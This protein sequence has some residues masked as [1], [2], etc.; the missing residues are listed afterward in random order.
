MRLWLVPHGA[1]ASEG[2]YLAYPLDDLLRLLALESHRHS[3]IVIGEDLGTVPPGFRARCARAG[4]AGMDVL[5]FERK[6]GRL[7]GADATGAAMRSRMTTTHDLPTV[8]GWWRGARHPNCAARIALVRRRRESRQRAQDRTRAV[9]RLHRRRR[10][11][12][13]RR[14]RRRHRRR[15]SM[16]RSASSR[17]RRRRWCWRRSRTCWARRAAQPAGHD[18]RASQLAPPPR[19]AGGRGCSPRPRSSSASP[20]SARGARR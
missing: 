16:R 8:A 20:C 5:W 10:R 9:A 13:R 2:A 19:P 14:R 15:P 17:S 3:A 11:Q 12:R 6:R 1:P 4:I 7:P 18:R